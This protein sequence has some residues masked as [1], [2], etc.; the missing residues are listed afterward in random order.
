MNLEPPITINSNSSNFNSYFKEFINRLKF[1]GSYLSLRGSPSLIYEH[2]II[3]MSRLKSFFSVVPIKEYQQVISNLKEPIICV[4]DHP[5]QGN[6]LAWNILNG[7]PT[8]FCPQNIEAL[9][10]LAGYF[11]SR[12]RKEGFF[13]RFYQEMNMLS[14]CDERFCISKV[15]A[16]LLSGL[17]IPSFYYPYLPVG[18]IRAKLEIIRKKRENNNK[19]IDNKHFLILGTAIH[20]TTYKSFIWFINQIVKEGLPEKVHI[21]IVGEGTEE[22][23]DEITLPSCI[24]ILGWLSQDA[25]DELLCE[26]NAVI[27]PQEIG[28][29]ALTRLA[30]MSCAGVPVIVSMHPTYA[31]N[32]PP[33]IVAVGVGWNE[34]FQKI[35]DISNSSPNPADLNYSSWEKEQ[36][37]PLATV[38]KLWMNKL[39]SKNE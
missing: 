15:E 24:N 29:G 37:H 25:L 30:E 12:F 5:N 21:T 35:K 17:G 14:S 9:D 31:I 4:I 22:L 27:I 26:I 18:D 39:A 2:L 13:Q 28:F 32:M 36:P 6:L 33:G 34:W 11:E 20:H 23:N 38:I 3:E 7:I 19:K 1:L 16:G 8:F 10:N